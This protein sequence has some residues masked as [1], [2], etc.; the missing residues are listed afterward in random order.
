[1]DFI[2]L[3]SILIDKS[4]QSSIPNYFKNCEVPIICYKFNK[5]FKSVA[6]KIAASLNAFC[7]RWCK[8]EHVEY[9]ALKAW[10]LNILK[11]IDRH[12]SFYSQ[13]ANMLPRKPKIS[14][15]YLTSGIEEFHRKVNRKAMIRNEYNHIPHLTLNTKRERRTHTEFYQRPRKTRTINRINSSFQNR[16]S[17]SYPN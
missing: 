12:I 4:V 2:D 1:M 15:H 16:W 13:S 17:F 8:R 7:N 5:P 3:P 11:I 9:D 6:N 10:K 14:Y